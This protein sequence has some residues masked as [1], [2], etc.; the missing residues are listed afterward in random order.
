MKLK[1]K[2]TDNVKPKLE[3]QS[4]LW[5]F[6]LLLMKLKDG[7]LQASSMKSVRLNYYKLA[8]KNTI[9]FHLIS[10]NIYQKNISIDIGLQI[11]FLIMDLSA[12]YFLIIYKM[13][14]NTEICP[15]QFPKP[16]GV[17]FTMACFAT[18][19]KTQR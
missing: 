18:R 16:Q 1:I 6:S 4:A 7:S 2:L 17:I 3:N 19:F 10:H 13:S 5:T 8:I 11:T 14:K 9:T 15:S 12:N